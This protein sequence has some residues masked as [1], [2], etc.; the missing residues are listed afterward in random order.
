MSPNLFLNKINKLHFWSIFVGF[1]TLSQTH[2]SRWRRFKN[3]D[4]F[5]SRLRKLCYLKS[6]SNKVLFLLNIKAVCYYKRNSWNSNGA[7][8][9]CVGFR[10]RMWQIVMKVPWVT[11]MYNHVKTKCTNQRQ[12]VCKHLTLHNTTKE[13]IS[14]SSPCQQTNPIPSL[15]ISLYPQ[16]ILSQ[17]LTKTH[18]WKYNFIT[19]YHIY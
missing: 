14:P 9:N 2:V 6:S 11:L 4:T 13:T 15:F 8:Q 12:T 17:M 16:L 5:Q 19:I 7:Q 3:R 18:S 1:G 10:G